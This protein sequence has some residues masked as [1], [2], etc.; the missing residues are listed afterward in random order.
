MTKK[1]IRIKALSKK[2]KGKF[3]GIPAGDAE[4]VSS[5]SFYPDLTKMP[6]TKEEWHRHL[7][8]AREEARQSGLHAGRREMEE[9]H[10]A[11]LDAFRIDQADVKTFLTA[12]GQL[13]QSNANLTEAVA[14]ALLVLERR[15]LY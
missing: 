10:K 15:A 3:K 11:S 14:R 12:A 13:A 9:K 2:F 8:F 6:R 5:A 1:T 4:G 7:Q